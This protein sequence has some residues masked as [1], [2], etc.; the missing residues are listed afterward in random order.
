LLELSVDASLVV[1]FRDFLSL[2]TQALF[3]NH[4]VLAYGRGFSS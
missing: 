2:T 3:L 4:G 1:A